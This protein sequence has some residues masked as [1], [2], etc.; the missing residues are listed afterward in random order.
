MFCHTRSENLA[1]ARAMV[2]PI[3]ERRMGDQLLVYTL[4]DILI[5]RYRWEDILMLTFLIDRCAF[6]WSR[7]LCKELCSLGALCSTSARG[8]SESCGLRQ[9]LRSLSSRKARRQKVQRALDK[10]W[11]VA[12]NSFGPPFTKH[13]PQYIR[14]GLKFRGNEDRREA[15][16]RD[17][18]TQICQ[19][20]LQVPKLYRRTNPLI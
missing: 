6:C 14:L 13:T 2:R 3:G 18:E 9:Q 15:F 1:A 12:L 16:R 7:I 11:R 19:L 17:C 20:G 5:P 4:V 8:R 10:W